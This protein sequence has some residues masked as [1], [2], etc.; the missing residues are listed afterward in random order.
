MKPNIK[1]DRNNKGMSGKCMNPKTKLFC[2]STF[3]LQSAFSF[4]S[5][6]IYIYSVYKLGVATYSYFLLLY[7]FQLFI[8]YVAKKVCT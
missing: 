2:L 1:C 4:D 5:A 3:V 6:N 8:Q 7:I